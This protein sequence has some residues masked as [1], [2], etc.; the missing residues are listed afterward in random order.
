MDLT[1]RVR[2]ALYRMRTLPPP[3]DAGFLAAV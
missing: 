2:Q 3:P 1:Y